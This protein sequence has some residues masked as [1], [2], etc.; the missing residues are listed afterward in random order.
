[1]YVSLRNNARIFFFKFPKND[2]F[3]F[4]EGAIKS[5]GALHQKRTPQQALVSGNFCV[6]TNKST[7]Y[8]NITFQLFF[9]T[10]R[11]NDFLGSLI[12]FPQIKLRNRL[13]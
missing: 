13:K 3:D 12:I 11:I 6:T 4:S 10:K 7:L 8:E 2:F 9:T 1:M 5:K